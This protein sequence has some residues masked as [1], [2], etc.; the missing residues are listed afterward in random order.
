VAIEIVFETHSVT[1]DNENGIA[2]GWLP[3][4]LSARGR[5]LAKQLGERRRDDGL[6]AV[7]TSDLM[8]AVETVSI[9]FEGSLP[10]FLD[11][12]LRECNYGAMN[13][14]PAPEVHGDRSAW[15]GMPYP[16]GESWEQAVSRVERALADISDFL[17]GSRV[18]VIGHI[19]TRWGLERAAN[20]RSIPELIAEEFRWQEGWEYRLG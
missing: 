13:G 5:E 7:F 12:R 3:G 11:W 16:D 14:Q 8:R 9:A 2:T 19:A 6:A 10:V 1:E 15:I 20:G 4:K 17:Q 18:L